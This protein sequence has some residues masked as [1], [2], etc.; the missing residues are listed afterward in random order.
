[1]NN[2][3]KD[4]MQFTKVVQNITCHDD[5]WCFVHIHQHAFNNLPLISKVPNAFSIITQL[6]FIEA[7]N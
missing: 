1:M 3:F 4:A 2:R 5:A 7:L 6:A